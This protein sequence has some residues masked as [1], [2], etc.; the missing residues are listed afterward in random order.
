MN[1][2]QP[3]SKTVPFISTLQGWKGKFAGR[4]P[5]SP[6]QRD[7]TKFHTAWVFSIDVQFAVEHSKLPGLQ[8][9]NKLF[10]LYVVISC[11]E[12]IVK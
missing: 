10:N 3:L 8:G 5:I 9:F 12:R 2:R 1:S 11:E 7:E 6:V 4:I